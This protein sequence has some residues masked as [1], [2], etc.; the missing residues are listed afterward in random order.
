MNMESV[1]QLA[2]YLTLADVNVDIVGPAL[3]V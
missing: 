3:H 2:F 1:E